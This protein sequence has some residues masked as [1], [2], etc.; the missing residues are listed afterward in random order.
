MPQCGEEG[1]CERWRVGVMEGDSA[2]VREKGGCEG[3]R[4][5]VTEEGGCGGRG[6]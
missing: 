4:E 3:K 6:S 1:G 2:G 5:G